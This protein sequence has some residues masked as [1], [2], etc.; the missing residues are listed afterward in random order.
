MSDSPEEDE[1]LT[2]VRMLSEEEHVRRSTGRM[3]GDELDDP[4]AA[5]AESERVK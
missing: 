5:L 2:E 1:P 3:S 4:M